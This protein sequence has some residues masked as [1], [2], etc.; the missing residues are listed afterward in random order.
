MKRLLRVVFAGAVAAGVAFI[1]WKLV[2]SP[3]DQTKEGDAPK[4][5]VTQKSPLKYARPKEYW[6]S[7]GQVV[8]SQNFAHGKIEIRERHMCESEVPV[9]YAANVVHNTP[10]AEVPLDEIE[11]LA[12]NSN[13]PIPSKIYGN[14]P[15]QNKG[16][17]TG[18][19]IATILPKTFRSLFDFPNTATEISVHNFVQGDQTKRVLK[20]AYDNG[21]TTTYTAIDYWY[22]D[23]PTKDVMVNM[24][25]IAADH[26]FFRLKPAVTVCPASP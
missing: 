16:D 22:K 24:G 9:C 6:E 26:P 11:R 3:A 21:T 18:Y 2:T 23:Q 1:G 12:R 8:V 13:V 7:I 4:S 15:Y 14:I 10:D 19:E 25:R 20:C 17:L 5:G